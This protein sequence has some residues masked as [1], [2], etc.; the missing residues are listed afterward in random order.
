[1]IDSNG[2]MISANGTGGFIDTLGT[3]ALTISGSN[4]LLYTYKDTTGTNRS[5]QVNYTTKSVRTNFGCSG[6]AEYGPLNQDLITSIV[7]PNGTSYQFTYETTPGYASSVTGRLAQV[8]LPTGGTIS[9]SY[10]NGNNGI[11]CEDGTTAAMHRTTSDGNTVYGRS[12]SGSIWTTN[13][14]PPDHNWTSLTFQKD[15]ASGNFYE[16]SRTSYI[17]SVGGTVSG[18]SQTCYNGTTCGSALTQ[19]IVI[20]RITSYPKLGNNQMSKRDVFINTK[21]LT[22]AVYEYDFGYNTPGGLLR[23]TITSYANLGGY[24][25]DRPEIITVYDGQNNIQAQTF[26]YYDQTTPTPTSNV[27][28]HLAVAWARGNLTKITRL[29]ASGVNPFTTFAYD[30][31]G[32]VISTTDPGGHTTTIDYSDDYNDGINHNSNAFP[33]TITLPPTANSTHVIKAKYYWHTGQKWQSI[34]QNNQ[35]TTYTFDSSLRLSTVGRPDAGSSTFIY[36]VSNGNLYTQQMDYMNPNTLNHWVLFDGYGRSS[37]S[38]LVNGD[39]STDQQDMCYD[40]MGR[41][42]FVSYPYKGSGLG[43][44]KI[45]SGAGDTYAYSFNGSNFRTTITHQDGTYLA[46]ESYGRAVLSA[47]EGNGIRQ[48][49]RISQ[50]DG[51]GRTTSICELT[52]IS[53]S[54]AE[55]TPAQCGQDIS[56]VGFFTSY[57]YDT[58]N[59]LK[60]VNQ[61]AVIRTYNYDTLS[62]LISATTPESATTS[63]TYDPDGNVLTRVRPAPNQ[64]QASVTVTTTYTHDQLHRLTH[65]TYSDNSTPNVIFG[66]D[67]SQPWGQAATNPKGHMTSAQ[68]FNPSTGAL[69]AGQIFRWHDAMGRVKTN[70]QCTI[71]ICGVSQSDLNYTYDLVGNVTSFSLGI[72]ANFNHSYDAAGRLTS[73]TMTAPPPDSTHPGSLF[74]A[75]KYNALGQLLSASLGNG[76]TQ[77][78]TFDE[79]GR[80]RTIGVGTNCTPTGNPTSCAS[81]QYS[82]TGPASGGISYHPNGSIAVATDQ[83]NGTW[84]Y[85]YDDLSR[86]AASTKTGQSPISFSYDRYGNRWTQSGGAQFSFTANNNRI[87]GYCYDPAGNLLKEGLCPVDYATVPYKYD[88]E[89]RMILA[90]GATYQYDALGRRVRKTVGGVST[91]YLFDLAGRAVVAMDGNGTPIRNELYAGNMHLVT[92]ANNTTYFNHTDWLGTERRRTDVGGSNYTDC[93]SLPFGDGQSCTSGNPSPMHFTGHERDGESGFDH[94]LFRQYAS[95]QGRWTSPDPLA[96]DIGNPQTLNRYAYVANAPTMFVD[97]LGLN[98]QAPPSSM[99]WLWSR[100]NSSVDPMYWGGFGSAAS[101]VWDVGLR[102]YLAAVQLNFSGYSNVLCADGTV[103]TVSGFVNVD[104]AA[105]RGVCSGHTGNVE[106]YVGERRVRNKLLLILSLWTASHAYYGFG[107]SPANC[108]AQYEVLGTDGRYNQQVQE[109]CGLDI[110]SG[111]G[112][113]KGIETLLHISPAQANALSE[114]SLY[115]ASGNPCPTCTG[116]DLGY[117]FL[118]NNSN[119]FVYNMLWRNPAGSILPPGPFLLLP[120]YAPKGG[121]WYP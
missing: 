83:V 60:Q 56:G 88:A 61:G 22:T 95:W 54:G 11:V 19:P 119:S 89:N 79:R 111:V 55:G 53:Q 63:F 30:D 109:T 102:Q 48:V 47:D 33:T 41:V 104:Q 27:P 57:Q 101:E 72:N 13:I 20:S 106:I 77:V 70:S 38:F 74:A 98:L 110:Q 3:T 93:S 5:V 46:Q 87:D 2:N 66:Y 75:A 92:Y 44:A 86:L 26:F 49:R 50:V 71:R 78:N 94:T 17:G 18:S 40:S 31:T 113:R 68:T 6:F 15:T 59:N 45:C 80:P 4:P 28:Q 121:T 16:Q 39:G 105:Q 65:K 85:T 8:T 62:R 116:G 37:R 73:V 14:D 120:A 112:N 23:Q 76:L 82:V 67:E 21:G 10:F 96:G 12:Q 117:N 1:M 42:A 29:L 81:Y 118:F 115:F 69:I 9:Y 114:R 90:P 91:D 36:G 24:A 58:L 84:T 7:F 97:P 99:Y 32:N 103:Q 100:Y 34:D 35:T 43:S 108:T 64:S 25:S 52:N 107:P 51:L